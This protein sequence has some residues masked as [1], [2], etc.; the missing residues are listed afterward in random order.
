MSALEDICSYL[1]NSAFK[2]NTTNI[3]C[4]WTIL[5]LQVSIEQ[6]HMLKRLQN[7]KTIT[8]VSTTTTSCI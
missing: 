1:I 3:G 8:F 4:Q 7:G 5:F 6:L 2:S